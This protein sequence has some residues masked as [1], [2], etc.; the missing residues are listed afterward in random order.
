VLELVIGS[1]I[2][3]LK[4]ISLERIQQK[5]F[6]IRGHKVMIERDLAGLYGVQTRAFNQT[7]RRNI[8]R[9]P[10]DFMLP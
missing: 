8:E 5:I 4:M 1:R 10:E 3:F 6:L 9:F 7:V 2:I